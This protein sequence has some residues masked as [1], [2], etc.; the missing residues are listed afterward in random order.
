MSLIYS[1]FFLCKFDEK[2]G[3]DIKNNISKKQ[4]VTEV[5]ITD[6]SVF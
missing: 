4:Y 2:K 3:L 1:H 5:V 6:C